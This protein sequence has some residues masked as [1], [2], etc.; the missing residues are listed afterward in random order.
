LCDAAKTLRGSVISA[1]RPLGGGRWVVQSAY[2]DDGVITAPMR[3]ILCL[4][5]VLSLAAPAILAPIS[6]AGAQGGCLSPREQQAEVRSGRVVRPGQLGRRL[7]GKVLRI[8]LCR[9][10]GGL[11]WR[12]TV[13]RPD[14]RVVHR[15]VDARSGR[16]LG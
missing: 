4:L 3:M 12:V 9:G 13:L 1:R 10:G 5:L 2:T 6:P 7:G 16:I 8:N 11:V 14:G 15:R